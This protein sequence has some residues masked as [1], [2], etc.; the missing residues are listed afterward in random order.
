MANTTK[1]YVSL[2]RLSDFLDN[3]KANYSQ[4]GHKHTIS[5]ITDYKVDS[6]LSS[7]S[8]NSVQNKVL[9]AEF[10]SVATAMN[11]LEDA[12]DKKSSVQ[13]DGDLLSTL[14]IHK[15]TQ[16]EYEQML[17]SGSLDETA[18]Y[19]TPDD[20]TDLS[21]YATKEDLI[22]KANVNH[23]HDD[24][25]YTEVEV[26]TLLLNKSDANHNHDT[27]YDAKGAADTA[28]ATAKSYTD[29]KTSSLA[30]TS[31]V[32]TKIGTHNTSSVAH[33]DIR[34]LIT[35]LTTR[36]N[37]LADSDD[38]TL[39]QLSEIVAYIKSNR[40][41]I[42]SVTTSKINVSDIVNNLT[43]NSTSKV[44]SAAQGVAIKSLI[45]TLQTEL[46]SKL[47]QKSQVQIITWEDDD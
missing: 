37:A 31:A 23:I 44:L 47:A 34:S 26:D 28:L 9:D 32:D 43:T 18:L 7:T 3:I 21:G 1:K 11:T 45:D 30:S 36:L 5:E 16:E 24:M 27:A 22:E 13:L 29:T 25:Y 20:T 4:I 14:N 40:T 17:A 38:A 12:I 15:L 39:D 6:S 8:T 19:L 35:T 42:E 10:N 33:S 46:D 2:A 41:L